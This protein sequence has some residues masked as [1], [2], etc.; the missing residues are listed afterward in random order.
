MVQFRWAREHLVITTTAPVDIGS[1]I[2]SDPAFR[3]GRPCLAGAGM[4]VHAV[5]ARYNSGMT[6]EQIQADIPDLD[7]V[8]FYAA[9]TYYLA[10]RSQIDAEIEAEQKL[11]DEMAAK[12]PNGW[13][14]GD[15]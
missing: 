7:L 12:Y 13:R 5:A 15:N 1:L 10:N 8:L 6:L 9:I 11:Y 3:D 2:Y 14:R 4:R